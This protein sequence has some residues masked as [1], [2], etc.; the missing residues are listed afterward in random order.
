LEEWAV[1]DKQKRLWE[2]L[3]RTISADTDYLTKVGLVNN[4][5]QVAAEI[6]RAQ[7]SESAPSHG[8][9]DDAEEQKEFLTTWPRL[10]R[11]LQVSEEDGGGLLS[12]PPFE[13]S[14]QECLSDWLDS[15]DAKDLGETRAQQE[16][17]FSNTRQYRSWIQNPWDVTP[18]VAYKDPTVQQFVMEYAVKVS[19]AQ[20]WPVPT[21]MGQAII[22][23]HAAEGVDSHEWGQDSGRQMCSSA[24]FRK[25]VTPHF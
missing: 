12:T 2:E 5:R 20:Q 10:G 6:M 4:N 17:M 1:D 14:Y 23:W 7:D 11:L 24:L 16:S 15:S 13:A 21:T 3:D 9:W 8:H 22:V 19:T 18:E 25:A